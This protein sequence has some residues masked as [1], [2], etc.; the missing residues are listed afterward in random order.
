MRKFPSNTILAKASVAF[1]LLCVSALLAVRATDEPGGKEPPAEPRV[2][3]E[4][5]P[6]AVTLD[7]VEML[8]K[9]LADWKQ[10]SLVRFQ[11][12]VSSTTNAEGQKPYFSATY[13]YPEEFERR[14]NG[15]GRFEIHGRFTPIAN[16]HGAVVFT[17]WGEVNESVHVQGFPGPRGGHPGPAFHR[18]YPLLSGSTRR[19]RLHQY[20]AMLGDPQREYL[21]PPKNAPRNLLAIL[22][23][24]AKS[25]VDAHYIGPLTDH[26]VRTLPDMVAYLKKEPLGMVPPER[27]EPLLDSPNPWMAWLGLLRLGKLGALRTEHFARAA[28]SRGPGD[29]PTIVRETTDAALI[30]ETVRADLARQIFRVGAT[31]KMREAVLRATVK[32]VEDCLAASGETPRSAYPFDLPGIQKAAREYR[33]E[34]ND[35]PGYNGVVRQ[36]DALIALP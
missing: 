17:G 33:E 10:M 2:V 29:A 24:S 18:L 22:P 11:T 12:A 5:A 14:G 3:A 16:L 23:Q 13:A 30:H 8:V 4:P 9:E 15:G 34:I 7:L 27:L 36:L 25:P 1:L 21:R 26:D 35:R 32:M 19:E 20:L 31:P 6:S 28:R